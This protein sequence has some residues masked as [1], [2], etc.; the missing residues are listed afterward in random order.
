MR[1]IS[2]KQYGQFTA[3][4]RLN[5]T[6]AALSRGDLTEADRLWY[7]C[8]R[9]LY[10]AHDFEYTLSINAIF[11]LKSTFFEQCILLY[12]LIKK[13]ELSIISFE[14]ELA[15]EEQEGIDSLAAQTK[16]LIELLQKTKDIHISRLKGLFE[17][18]KQF[19]VKVNIN[20]E[21]I[22]QLIP[23][24]DCCQEL[25]ILLSADIEVD[26]DYANKAKV[27]FL[28]NSHF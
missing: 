27:F 8:P 21:T 18:F 20:D 15:F 12:N 14:Q 22:L 13:S 7:T 25:D 23:L 26:Q 2:D 5:L 9:R 4:E 6:V 11:L 19:C 16:K 28:E 24:K 17:G 3:K 1:Q 10:Q